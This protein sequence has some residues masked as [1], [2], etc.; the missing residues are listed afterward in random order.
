[1]GDIYT[2]IEPLTNLD[3]DVILGD[4][5]AE[6]EKS[7]TVSRWIREH[8]LERWK[9]RKEFDEACLPYLRTPIGG[10]ARESV[11][12]AALYA[13]KGF[14]GVIQIYPLGCMPE[15]VAAGVLTAVSENEKI[16]VLTLV[17]DEMTGEAG[18]RTRIEA[19]LDVLE[20]RRKWKNTISA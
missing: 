9:R 18:Y 12:N 14:D 3:I 20:K 15:I 17:V 13:K 4:L 19:F 8:F 11:G 7:L 10:H 6:T 5:G 16:P 2:L 1:V